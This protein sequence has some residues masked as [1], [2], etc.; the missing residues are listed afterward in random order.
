VSGWNRTVSDNRVVRQ[1]VFLAILPVYSLTFI[2]DLL[3]LNTVEFWSGENP[4]L[5]D[6]GAP[7][8]YTRVVAHGE[9]RAVQWFKR[10]GE[11]R[12]MTAAIYEG[13]RLVRRITLR[14][15]DP[16]A[17]LEVR[18]RDARGG[19]GRARLLPAAGGAAQT[20]S[21]DAR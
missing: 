17:A 18:W 14:Q 20:V 8:G 21:A 1:A 12:Q 9:Q 3:V 6:T 11:S 15:P 16:A 7:V 10:S 2:G 4:M 13:D 5:A 19:E